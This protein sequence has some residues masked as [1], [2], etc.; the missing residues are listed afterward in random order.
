MRRGDLVTIAVSGDYGKPR[1]AVVMQDD[2]FAELPSVTVLP[3]TSDVHEEHAI[4]ITVE[5]DDSNSLRK[6]SQI[7]VDRAVTVPRGKVGTVFGRLD[8]RT[9][10]V[11][12]VALARF[13]GLGE[14]VA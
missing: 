7:I 5:P 14:R 10:S 3:I 4:R 13:L 12:D 8:H 1:P 9:L 2:A 11:V 6:P